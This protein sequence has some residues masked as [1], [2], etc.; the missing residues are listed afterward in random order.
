MNKPVV[1]VVYCDDIRN[2]MGNKI[3]LMGIYDSEL[4]TQVFPVN[5]PKL[6]AQIMVKFPH[7]A[8]P[9]STLKIELLNG[10]E[11]MGAFELDKKALSQVVPPKS[12][13]DVPKD[14]VSVNIQ[15][16][17][18]L[19]PLKLEKPSTLRVHCHADK[20]L[21]K[22]NALVL[23]SATSQELALMGLPQIIKQENN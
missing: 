17:F 7:N 12:G 22:G 16:N 6:C 10:D 23:R 21:Y 4:V 3:S 2:E 20:K 1:H 18:V 9:K 15:V 13:E 14:E 11:S 19:S 8:L 5:L